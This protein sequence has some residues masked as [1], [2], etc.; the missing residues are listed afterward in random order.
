[1]FIARAYLVQFFNLLYS[2]N[3]TL[4]QCADSIRLQAHSFFALFR[5]PTFMGKVRTT[6]SRSTSSPAT[7]EGRRVVIGI[8]AITSLQREDLRA[9]IYV[10][11][12]MYVCQSSRGF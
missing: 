5:A 9:P 1:M 3:S 11:K 10:I 8:N 2:L 6:K 4:F 7:S 12:N